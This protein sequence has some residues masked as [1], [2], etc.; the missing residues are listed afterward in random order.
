MHALRNSPKTVA[1][2]GGDDT[3]SW[4]SWLVSGL[5]TGL[6]VNKDEQRRRR[7]RADD[8]MNSGGCAH[9]RPS[10]ERTLFSNGRLFKS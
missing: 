10:A 4:L 7:L 9:I 5:F 2:A 3:T 6:S 8:E 1:Y